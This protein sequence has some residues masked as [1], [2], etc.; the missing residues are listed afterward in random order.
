MEGVLSEVKENINSV[1]DEMIVLLNKQIDLL[2]RLKKLNSNKAEKWIFTYIH[3]D[4]H[5]LGKRPTAQCPTCHSFIGDYDWV[6]SHT[7]SCPY[8]Y[9]MIGEKEDV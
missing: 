5:P 7:Y 8:C 6:V 3:D 1:L 2:K 4:D 9:T